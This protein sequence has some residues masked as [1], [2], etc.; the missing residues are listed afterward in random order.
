MSAVLD[1]LKSFPVVKAI[2]IVL[3]TLLCLIAVKLVLTIYDKFAK[4]RKL[5]PLVGKI[6]RVTVKIILLFITVILPFIPF[7]SNTPTVILP[8]SSY[9]AFSADAGSHANPERSALD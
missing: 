6:L 4:K 2:Y 7:S 5:D 1:Y 3:L 9:P 8:N